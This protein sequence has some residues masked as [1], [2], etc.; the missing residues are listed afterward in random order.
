[1]LLMRSCKGF[2][3]VTPQILCCS[4]TA[5][6]G[7]SQTEY[8][9]TGFSLPSAATL[10]LLACYETD[11][12]FR[13]PPPPALPS[14]PSIPAGQDPIANAVIHAVDFSNWPGP[15]NVPAIVQVNETR[16]NGRVPIRS[17]Q[18]EILP[19]AFSLNKVEANRIAG[20]TLSQLVWPPISP[21]HARRG[22]APH[23]PHRVKL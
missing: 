5:C 7:Y 22:D 9:D 21:Q 17:F 8:L 20:L 12:T 6:R 1:M 10:P 15:G 13:P 3:E 4:V 18:T 14:G 11:P 19:G 16:L 2:D 23:T